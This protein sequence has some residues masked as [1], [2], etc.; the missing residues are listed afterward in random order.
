MLEQMEET[1]ARYNIQL[2][3]RFWGDIDVAALQGALDALVA[4]HEAVG[5]KSTETQGSA[6]S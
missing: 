3:L 2:G 4:R 6:V 1:A 5:V